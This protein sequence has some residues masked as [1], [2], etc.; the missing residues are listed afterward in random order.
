M[1]T[2]LLVSQRRIVHE[3]L[4][5]ENRD[6]DFLFFSDPQY[7]FERLRMPAI[8]SVLVCE[9]WG[10]DSCRH[11]VDTLITFRRAIPIVVMLRARNSKHEAALARQGVRAIVDMS[12]SIDKLSAILRRAMRI[13]NPPH[14]SAPPASSASPAPST[15]P[16]SYSRYMYSTDADYVQNDLLAFNDRITDTI[17]TE[18]RETDREHTK[19]IDGVIDNLRIQ[20]G[21]SAHARDIHAFINQ[22]AACN[23]GVL[24]MGE[25]GTGKDLVATAIHHLSARRDNR[26]IS[27]NCGAIPDTLFESEMFGSE[28][29]AFTGAKRRHG[30][31]ELAQYG[32]LFLNEIGEMSLYAQAKL[33]HA[34]EYKTFF[35]V[36]G[37]RM[38]QCDIRI[39]A[40]TNKNLARMVR[41]NRFREDLYYRIAI[42]HFSMPSLRARKEDIGYL[43]WNFLRQYSSNTKTIT[44]K[45][46]DKLLSHEWPGNIRELRN[47]IERSVAHSQ[48]NTITDADIIFLQ[49]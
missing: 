10:W 49:S 18:Y 43:T 22:C 1:Y 8:D 30:Y 3:H 35:S 45:A 21:I 15:S 41:E 37:E 4:Q 17:R 24:I 27:V 32:T 44:N 48:T 6:I 42:L 36:G 16:A 28:P 29:G 7:A 14:P 19:Y 2:T 39:I 12:L 11:F 5:R 23:T 46:I 33:L 9:E 34:V 20:I 26:I 31:F 13:G 47:C 40:A 38:R 25:S